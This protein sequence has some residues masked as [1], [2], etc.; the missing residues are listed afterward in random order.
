MSEDLSVTEVDKIKYDKIQKAKQ[1]EMNVN[2]AI[3]IAADLKS[4]VQKIKEEICEGPDCLKAKVEDKFGTMENKFGTMEKKFDEIDDK[5][6]KIGDKATKIEEKTSG[7]VCDRCGYSGVP[8]LS[9]YCP[10]CGSPIFSWDDD[11]GKPVSGWKHWSDR[12]DSKVS[13]NEDSKTS[14]N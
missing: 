14:E 10:Q 4:D 13:D 12:E 3:R 6:K 5:I 8:P 2:D 1:F 11:E 9:S 7:F